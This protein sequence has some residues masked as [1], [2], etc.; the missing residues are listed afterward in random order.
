MPQGRVSEAAFDFFADSKSVYLL[1]QLRVD[2]AGVHLFLPWSCERRNRR[3]ACISS[4]QI[5]PNNRLQVCGAFLH[6]VLQPPPQL[7]VLTV[8]QESQI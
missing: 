8:I 2:S 3:P 1:F 5:L 7:W 4:F 6:L